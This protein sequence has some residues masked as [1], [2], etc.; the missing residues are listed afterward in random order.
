M[1]PLTFTWD[2]EAMVPKSPR[3]ADKLYVVGEEYR[4]APHEERSINAHNHY[5]ACLTESWRNLPEDLAM[6]F[7]SVEH[8]RKWALVKAGYRDERSIAC[9][10]K[11][12]ALRLGAFIRPMDDFAVVVVNEATVTVMTAKSQSMRAMG[13]AEFT[14]SKQK[15]L[16]VVASMIGV[17]SKTLAENSGRAA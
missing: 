1:Q 2:G 16:D 10:S 6:R 13:R 3:M 17:S 4:L 12:E 14:D 11:A 15:V 5:F 9:S 7:Q 8:L